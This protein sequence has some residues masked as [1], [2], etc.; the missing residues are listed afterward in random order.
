MGRLVLYLLIILA[1]LFFWSSELW[2]NYLD[3]SG[4][5]ALDLSEDYQRAFL[6]QRNQLLL[7]ELGFPLMMVIA[8]A[9]LLVVKLT[10]K[11]VRYSLGFMLGLSMEF[12]AWRTFLFKGRMANLYI[13]SEMQDPQIMLPNEFQWF[14]I[15]FGVSLALIIFVREIPFDQDKEAW[16]QGLRDS[17]RKSTWR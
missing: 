10:A 16:E 13:Q 2:F 17:L 3:Y 11:S 14:M 5:S 8:F 6:F 7:S 12:W 9:V 1:G 15:G 4:H